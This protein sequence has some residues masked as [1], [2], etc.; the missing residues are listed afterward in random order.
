MERSPTGVQ[1]RSRKPHLV[2]SLQKKE[3]EGAAPIH[4]HSVELNILYDGAD[5]LAIPP[6]LWYK[7]WVVTAVESNGDL[8]PSKVLGGGGFDRH[9][10]LGCEFLLPLG[11][12]GIGAT[13]NLIY[14]QGVIRYK[15]HCMH[16]VAC[17]LYYEVIS[18]CIIA[19]VVQCCCFLIQILFCKFAPLVFDIFSYV[20]MV[21][22]GSINL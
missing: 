13:K 6:R 1:K 5:Y 11:H 16:Y 17:L 10:L 15:M 12:I 8:R 9:D 21:L 18:N 7:V 4:E 20:L 19:C 14:G 2:K 3:V 22:K